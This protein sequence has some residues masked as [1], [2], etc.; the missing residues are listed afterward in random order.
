MKKPAREAL[1]QLLE[2]V[3]EGVALVDARSAQWRIGWA[4]TA[5]LELTELPPGGERSAREIAAA[6]GGEA[7][8]QTL[9]AA[10]AE[11]AT[12]ELPVSAPGADTPRYLIKIQPVLTRKGVAT[13]ESALT[14]RAMSADERVAMTDE[15]REELQKARER[16]ESMSDDP[17]TSLASNDR[18]REQLA[19][20]VASARRENYALSLLIFT[21]DGFDRYLET[22]GQHATDSCLRMLARTISRRLRRNTDFAGRV[23]ESQIA[24]LMHGGDEDALQ[25]FAAAIAADVDALRIH[26][27]RS[28]VGRYVSMSTESCVLAHEDTSDVGEILDQI[29]ASASKTSGP[30]AVRLVVGNRDA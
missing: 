28:P 13:G 9:T 29:L 4:N 18:F 10:L 27:P 11:N 20:S 23:G 8:V 1:L 14:L 3:H 12:L 6:W 5:F 17:V 15:L 19:L 22:F 25:Q 24:L 16:L 26:H 2:T 21:V 7:L 30:A